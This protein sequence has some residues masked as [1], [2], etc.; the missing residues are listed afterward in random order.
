MP[1][2]KSHKKAVHVTQAPVAFPTKKLSKKPVYSMVIIYENAVTGIR[3]KQ[4][5]ENL[6]HELGEAI[7]WTRDMWDLKML[8]LADVRRAATEAAAIAD[9]VILGLD[10]RTDLPDSFKAWVEE[11]GGR[12]HGHPILIALFNSADARHL[13]LASTR[14]FL[15]TIAE[16]C[17][18]TFL[19]T[20][21][22]SVVQYRPATSHD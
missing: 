5:S 13:A 19:H 15:G 8:D 7:P 18:L 21:G 11:W 17:E 12:L 1:Q 4:F 9:V 20:L 6:M 2:S 14:S 22:E 10:G 16:T 3:A